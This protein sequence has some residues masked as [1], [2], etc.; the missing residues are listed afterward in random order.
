M[1]DNCSFLISNYKVYHIPSKEGI[2][3]KIG[4]KLLER[5]TGGRSRYWQVFWLCFAVAAALFLPHCIIDGLNGDF[6]HYAGDFNDQQ[7]SFY[8]YANN[9]VKQGGSFSWATDLGSGFVNS[10]S[11]YLCGSPFFWL[12]LLLPY[13]WTPWAMVPML[14]FKFAVAGGGAYLWMRRWVKDERWSMV[15]ACLY[16]FSGFTVYNVFFN[17]FLDVVALFPYMLKALDDTVLDRRHGAI[18]LL[19]CGQPAQQLFLFCR[20]GRVFDDLFCL[21]GGGRPVQ[22]EPAPVWGA[23]VPDGAGLL[24]GLCAAGSGGTFAGAEPAHNRSIQWV[25]LPCIRQRP[26]VPCHFLQ[27]FFDAGCP[28][29][30]RPVPGG[31]LKA[32]QHDRLPAGGGHCGRA[33]VLPRAAGATPLRAS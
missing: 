24:H 11:F 8:S 14:C 21:H 18:P 5:K 31:H 7:I 2:A 17:H 23:G 20:A 15:G 1:A 29:P 27:R 13:R 33:G 12:T 10:Y 25:R 9:F 28:L 30:E 16:A 19:G 3:L 4:G 26:A 6:F 32:H 22:A